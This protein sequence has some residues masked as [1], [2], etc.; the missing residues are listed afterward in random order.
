MIEINK[1]LLE[2][3]LI[4]FRYRLNKVSLKN[5]IKRK[6]TKNLIW[7]LN[8]TMIFMQL[9]KIIYW[10]KITVKIWIAQR[11]YASNKK[12]ISIYKVW[13]SKW[14]KKRKKNYESK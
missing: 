3:G 1:G 12:F 7:K 2:K 6:K 9:T 10:N 13:K 11:I 4:V 5:I 14:V 8:L